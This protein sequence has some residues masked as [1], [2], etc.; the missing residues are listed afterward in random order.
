MLASIANKM[1]LYTIV[2][3]YDSNAIGKGFAD[4]F[5]YLSNTSIKLVPT[6]PAP[7]VTT[8]YFFFI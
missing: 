7:P 4:H 2:F 6:K 1:G 5:V 3:D 8:I